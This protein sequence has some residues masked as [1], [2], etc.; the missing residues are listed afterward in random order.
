[1]N[2]FDVIV[3]VVVVVVV[4]IDVVVGV[5]VVCSEICVQKIEEQIFDDPT[6][7][8]YLKDFTVQSNRSICLDLS[9]VF[10]VR[11]RINPWS[12]WPLVE[13]RVRNV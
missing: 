3:V 12:Q 7:L 1:M 6:S 9:L 10:Q 2:C 13:Y 11:S 5:V 4:V 8:Q